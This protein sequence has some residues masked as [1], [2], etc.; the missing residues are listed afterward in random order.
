M[1]YLIK[2]TYCF[3]IVLSKHSNYFVCLS[4]ILT[5]IVTNLNS[6][7]AR[8]STQHH[9][10]IANAFTLTNTFR[11]SSVFLSILLIKISTHYALLTSKIYDWLRNVRVLHL[12]RL[13][14]AAFA[15][16]AHTLKASVYLFCSL[17]VE[18]R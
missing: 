16:D 12:S 5:E 14:M 7:F 13:T 4:H 2:N 15:L 18:E 17:Y 8:Q 9:A 6:R 1:L 11:Q 10:T 3:L